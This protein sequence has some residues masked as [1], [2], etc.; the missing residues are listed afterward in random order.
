M[1][2]SEN[3]ELIK[4]GFVNCYALRHGSQRILVDA[5]TKSAGKKLISFYR[6]RGEKPDLV[7]ITHYHPDHIGGLHMIYEEFKPEIYAPEIEIPV[8]QGKEKIES[9]KSMLS[10][11]VSGVSR[12]DAVEAVRP[13]ESLEL[14][15]IEVIPT[16][17]HT[18]GSVSYL[19]KEDGIIFIGDAFS[20]SSGKPKINRAFT[21]DIPKAE[22]SMNYVLSKKGM[23]ILPG[24]GEPLRT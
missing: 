11:L 9:T 15:F 19:F 20:V 14:P 17:G 22:A 16:P 6:E 23:T 21:L 2:I 7:L 4:A 18:P 5:G 10:K 12:I 8:I 1:K 24:H 13:A 3:V